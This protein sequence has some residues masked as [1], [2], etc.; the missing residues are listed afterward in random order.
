MYTSLWWLDTVVVLRK[1]YR[2]FEAL[3]GGEY[4]SLARVTPELAP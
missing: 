1:G 3:P 4:T 2:G